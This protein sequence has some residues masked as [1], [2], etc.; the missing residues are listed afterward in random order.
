MHTFSNFKREDNGRNPS[1]RESLN[2]SIN[3]PFVRMLRDVISY[4]THQQWQDLK[5]VMKNDDDPRRD[6]ILARFADREGVQFLSQ[7]WSK[8][9]GKEPQEQIDAFL[10]GLKLTQDRAAVIHRYLYPSADLE[11][12]SAFMNER[13]DPKFQIF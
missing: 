4:I 9:S 2:E 7:F 3:L 12:F 6:K 13:K 10:T 11:S 8:Y 5:A 1:V